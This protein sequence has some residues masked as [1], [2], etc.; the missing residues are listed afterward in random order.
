MAENASPRKPLSRLLGMIELD[1]K[2]VGYLYLFAA[3]SGLITLAVPLGVQA[4]IGLIQ[5]GQISTSLFLLVFIVSA[6]LAFAGGLNI[7]QYYIT[8]VIQQRIFVRAA[9]EY[10]YLIPRIKIE[11]LQNYYVPELVNRFFEVLSIQKGFSK[12]LTD[13][14]IAF[15]QTLF[16]LI[17]VSFY[18]PFFMIFG[19]IL[20]TVIG[21]LVWLTGP[22]GLTT[23]L[24]ES[25]HKFRVVHW[26]EDLG[27]LILSFKMAGRTKLPL[28]RTDEIVGDYINARNSHFKVLVLQY[29]TLVVFRVIITAVLLILGS[30]LVIQN[31]INLGQFVAAEIVIFTIMT[32]VEKVVLSMESVFDVLT[33]LEKVAAVTDLPEERT[34]GIDF[35]SIDE[36]HGISVI[37]DDIS[38]QYPYS[39]K[40]ALKNIKMDIKPGDRICIAGHIGS[41]KSTLVKMISGLYDD[42]EGTIT[43]N[44]LPRKNLNSESLR[45]MIGDYMH[46]DDIFSGSILENISLGRDSVDLDKV[47]EASNSV[48]LTDYIKTLPNGFDTLIQ[49]DGKMLSRGFA[50]KIKIARAIASNPELLSMDECLTN[51]NKIDKDKFINYL[52]DRER[53]WSV[54]MV[55]NDR[56]YASKCDKIYIVENGEII[57]HGDFEH[58]SKQSYFEDIFH[59]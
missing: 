44:G 1:K 15:V 55:S 57:D 39:E 33:A 30:I 26:L 20:V 51:M 23:S 19:I 7:I 47:I 11:S 32:S 9:F 8:E 18:H 50:K 45:S 27:R 21:F 17:L 48:N 40:Y 4:L 58:V 54:V 46:D 36:H 41:G 38:Y 13:F 37:L 5:G 12:L 42:F 49:A 14:S 29:I 6:A 16:G 43:Y 35:D 10:A 53:D 52:T 24:L 22:R 59:Y 56:E 28:K 34:G 31:E 25:K 3:F 2:D